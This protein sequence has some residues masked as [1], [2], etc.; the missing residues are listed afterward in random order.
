MNR[1]KRKQ[2]RGTGL[3]ILIIAILFLIAAALAILAFSENDQNNG[4]KNTPNPGNTADLTATPSPSPTPTPTPVPTPTPLP[5]FVPAAVTGTYP[6]EF[7]IETGVMVDGVEFDDYSRSAY[8]D[9]AEGIDYTDLE[10]VITF[11]GNNFREGS[12]Y[13]TASLKLKKFGAETW[14]YETGSLPKMYGEGSWTGSGWTGQPL[15]VKWPESTKKIMNMYDSA[16]QKK[17]LVEVIYATMDGNIYFLDS[18]TGEKT[19]DSIKTGFPFKGAGALDPRGIPML[20]LGAG[21]DSPLDGGKGA[22]A[23]IYSL[24]TG[25]KLYEFGANDLFTLRDWHAYDSSP[26]VDAET[27][28]LIYPGENGILYMMKLNTQYDENTGVLTIDPSEQI[29]WR[30]NT[31]RSGSEY[32]LGIEDSIIIWRSKAIFSDN[33][34]HLFCI[35][36]NTFKVEWVQDVLDDTNC[37]PVLELEDGHPYVYT[38]TSFHAGWRAAEGEKAVI[39][40]WKI[41]AVTGEV[42]WHTDYSCGTS[43]GVSGGV[44]GTIALGKNKLS[45][46]IFVPVSRN[47]STS[48]GKLAALDK[49]TGKERWVFEMERYPWSSPA[50]VYDEDGN[51]YIIQCNQAGDMYLLDGLTGELLDT[52]NLGSN[53]EA[54][55]SVFGNRVVVGT[56]GN[57][58]FG[59]TLE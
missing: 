28:T 6:D 45:E 27:D 49:A 21:D 31:E 53:I 29:K 43:S 32:W 36:L 38:S 59:I 3:R 47:P 17:D 18:E 40:V 58:I 15:L 13:G 56:R 46:L 41:D 23:F 30:Y 4:I 22:R 48:S 9:F 20:Y 33:G 34:G 24:V 19:R 10:G 25:E 44:Q 14:E 5:E 26:L 37:T 8:I 1:P 11:R 2:S 16:K 42:V 51:G 35:D 12:S 7:G 55:P 39:P 52:K 57:R 50:A 54:S